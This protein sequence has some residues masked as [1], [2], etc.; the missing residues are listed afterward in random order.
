MQDAIDKPVF[1]INGCGLICIA[2]LWQI[3]VYAAKITILMAVAIT[4]I[5]S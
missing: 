2:K 5:Y 1:F 4:I 3:R